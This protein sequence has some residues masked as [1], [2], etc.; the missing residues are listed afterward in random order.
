LSGTVRLRGNRKLW[1]TLTALSLPWGLVSIVGIGW[2]ASLVRPQGWTFDGRAVPIAVL[3]AT[4]V[5]GGLG[6]AVITVVLHEAVH[7]ILLWMV[8]GARP[9]F[10]FKVWYAYA[11]APGWYLRR[12]PMVAVLVA[13]LVV[14]PAAGLA[15]I[16]FTPPGVSIFVL[17]GLVINAIAAIADVYMVGL[18]L[19][20][21]GP[22]YFGDTPEAKTGEAGSWYLPARE[23][24][25]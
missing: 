10:G 9:V 25:A 22:V 1:A 19:R 14:L 20:I 16:A 17:L 11:D 7:G 15:L 6:T 12:W 18:A 5:G 8:T 3:I 21:R 4:I 2:L 23:P 24:A 13:P